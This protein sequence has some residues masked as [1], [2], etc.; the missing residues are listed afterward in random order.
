MVF[1]R[2]LGLIVS[3]LVCWQVYSQTYFNKLDSVCFG[4]GRVLEDANNFYTTGAVY[5]PSGSGSCVLGKYTMEGESVLIDTF[6]VDGIVTVGAKILLKNDEI[7]MVNSVNII[8]PYSSN[9][10]DLQFSKLNTDFNQIWSQNLG[11]DQQD[12]PSQLIENEGFIY[13]IGTTYSLGEGGGDFYVIKSDLNG[14]I[15]WEQTYGTNLYEVGFN[16]DFTNDGNLIITG[17]KRI[18]GIDWNIYLV[19]ITLDGSV[20]WEKNYGS[21]FNDYGSRSVSLNDHSFIVYRNVNDGNGGETIGYVEK[22]DGNGNLVWSKQFIY[23]SFS[24]FSNSRPVENP[25]GTIMVSNTC[26]NDQG[27]AI[28]RLIKLDP[29]GN[30]LW[31]KEYYTRPDLTQY[32]YDI[33]PT[34]DGGYIMSGSAFPVGINTQH[35]WLVKTN[36]NGE[37]GVQH[38][39]TTT[40]C[41]QYD[42]TLYPIDASFSATATTIDLSNGG[43][44]QFE[45]NSANAT[46]RVWNFG[47]G[48]MEYTDSLMSHTFTQTGTYEVQLVVFHGMCSDTMTQ[49][50]EVTNTSNVTTHTA[51]EKEV[52]LYPN[53]N[54]G[55]FTLQNNTLEPLEILIYDALG[56]VVFQGNTFSSAQTSLNLNLSSGVYQV[57]IR[58]NGTMVTKKM[59][60]K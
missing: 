45:N 21:N 4:Y 5:N 26:R 44:I 57:N 33:K 3:T 29:F 48:E 41:A 22:I 58:Q 56:K 28:N 1:T 19:K 25:D 13:I 42:C 46:S 17:Q 34:S 38:P 12:V 14:N 53:P 37:E 59:V 39:I 23:N 35:A 60:V 49:T 52:K 50:I 32:I 10:R 51:L 15:I 54:N 16:I 47:D 8:P 30:T 6:S 18:S 55:D 36:C 11:G 31:S 9:S 40:P 24:S 20:L 27:I 43:I 2:I 7:F